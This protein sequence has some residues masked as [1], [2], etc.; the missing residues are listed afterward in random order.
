ME[1]RCKNC[2]HFDASAKEHHAGGSGF[3][4]LMP[5]MP[6]RDDRGNYTAVFGLWPI[7]AAEDRCGEHEP[8]DP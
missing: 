1:R 5:P 3:C 4:R 2:Q 8:R 7:V 6:I